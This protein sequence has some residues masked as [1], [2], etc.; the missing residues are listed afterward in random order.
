MKE[1]PD[2]GP[3]PELK[4]LPP[5]VF[6]VDHHYQRHTNSERS[7]K[8]IKNIIENF[9][10]AR[11][12]PPTVTP[13]RGGKYL[14]IDGQHRI[15]GAQKRP[16]IKLIPVYVV[17]EMTMEKAAEHFVSINRDRVS[18]HPLA[19]Y[20]ALLTMGDKTA[21]KMKEICE[22]ADV[23][24]AYQPANRGETEPRVTAAVGTIKNGLR[25]YGEDN[26]LAALMIIPEAYKVAKGMMR[27][28]TLKALMRFFK[29]QGI[30]NVNRDALKYVLKEVPP[31]DAEDAAKRKVR[32]SGGN[33]NDYL[34]ADITAR[35]NRRMRELR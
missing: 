21:L 13:Y 15:K 11:W 20:R 33:S 28:A 19:V 5:D 35:Y 10:W 16:D 25:V 31:P 1:Y 3:K 9:M 7:R 4:W 6:V 24:I 23:S 26:V 22:E 12:Q 27:S 34:V 8:V 29:I 30:K 17:P 2:T 18:L 32:K 14:I